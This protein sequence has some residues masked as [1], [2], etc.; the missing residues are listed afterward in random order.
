MLFKTYTK[1]LGVDTWGFGLGCHLY[2]QLCLTFPADPL[3]AVET[4]N[5]GPEVVFK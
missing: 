1:S 4:R 2:A 3:E 5:W